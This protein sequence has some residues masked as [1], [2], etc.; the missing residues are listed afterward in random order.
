MS[1]E[2]Q[3]TYWIS[4]CS[5]V[6]Y[7]SKWSSC[8][9]GFVLYCSNNTLTLHDLSSL[10]IVGTVGCQESCIL[11]PVLS[12][13]WPHLFNNINVMKDNNINKHK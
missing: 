9:S 13:Y 10:Q 8:C 3:V 6:S 5:W 2:M 4:D 7:R 1:P 12:I 11:Y